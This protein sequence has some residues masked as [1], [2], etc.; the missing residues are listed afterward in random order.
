[1]LLRNKIYFNQHLHTRLVQRDVRF[2]PKWSQIGTKLI[3]SWEFFKISFQYILALQTYVETDLCRKPRWKRIICGFFFS[4]VYQ[5]KKKY[6]NNNNNNIV[7]IYIAPI[8]KAQGGLQEYS[9][10]TL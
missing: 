9:H 2:W 1:M 7:F 4:Q 3:K 6:V 10:I 8:Q 5:N